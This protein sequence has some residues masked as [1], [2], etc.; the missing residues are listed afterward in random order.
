MISS[1]Q[2]GTISKSDHLEKRMTDIFILIQEPILAPFITKYTF[3]ILHIRRSGSELAHLP[4]FDELV[5]WGRDSSDI[6][7]VDDIF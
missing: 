6:G 7:I 4:S 5:E 3:K 1:T 2:S